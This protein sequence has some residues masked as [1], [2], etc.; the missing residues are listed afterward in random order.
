MCHGWYNIENLCNKLLLSLIKDLFVA[1][2]HHNGGLIPGKLHVG[3]SSA[4]ISYGGLEISK[5]E[6]EASLC[7]KQF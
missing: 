5:T 1:R 6:Y 4:Y 7:F 2:G 3:H